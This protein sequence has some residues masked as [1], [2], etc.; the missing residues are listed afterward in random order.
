MVPFSGHCV[1]VTLLAITFGTD[2]FHYATF[3]A[4]FSHAFSFFLVA[5][6]LRVVLVTWAKPSASKALA[7]GALLALLTLVRPT[8]LVLLLFCA[9][10][11][12]DSMGSLRRRV[13]T[14]RDHAGL[15]AGGAAVFVITVIPQVVYWH[16]VRGKWFV[17][18][19]PGHLNLLHPHLIEVLFSVRK[20]LFF[21][22]PLLLLA[23][24]GLAKAAPARAGSRRAWAIAFLIVHT[25]VVASWN[26]WWYGGSFGMRPFVEALPILALGFAALVEAT[27]TVIARRALNTTIAATTLLAVHGMLA[28][29]LHDIPYDGTTWHTYLSSFAHP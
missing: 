20:G 2:L 9:L 25:W 19:D 14:F 5:L 29:W 16:A 10:V 8:N 17:Y 12:V 11:G 6:I 26:Q 4:V 15:I 23:V 21:W 24:A 28:Y 27:Q 7:L 1:I 22:T 3:D 13:A 18:A